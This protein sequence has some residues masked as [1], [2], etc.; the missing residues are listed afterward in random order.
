MVVELACYWIPFD[1]MIII[2]L[3]WVFTYPLEVFQLVCHCLPYS[4][5]QWPC[6]PNLGLWFFIS[7]MIFF[8]QGECPNMFRRSRSILPR[9]FK[10]LSFHLIGFWRLW[11]FNYPW[12]FTLTFPISNS[13]YWHV[14]RGF[15]LW[16]SHE[17]MFQTASQSIEAIQSYWST[18]AGY[19]IWVLM[20]VRENDLNVP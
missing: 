20:V 8:S 15:H 13:M 12:T 16:M 5:F 1:G 10:S 7:L 9:I 4:P 19:R 14:P 18:S 11:L 6:H 2:K 17:L 3:I